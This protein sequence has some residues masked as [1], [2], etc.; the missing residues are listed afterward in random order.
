MKAKNAIKTTTKTSVKAKDIESKKSP[1]GGKSTIKTL[2]HIFSALR[3]LSL[4]TAAFFLSNPQT[5]A[6]V[7]QIPAGISGELRVKPGGISFFLSYNDG[8]AAEK[9][10]RRSST[11]TER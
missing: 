10:F 2:R 11:P 4:S 3:R 1:K 9:H 6:T 7:L 5:A 8:A